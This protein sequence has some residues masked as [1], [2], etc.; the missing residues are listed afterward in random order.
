MSN[1][2]L[3]SSDNSV[4]Q[5]LI[6]LKRQ[7][8]LRTRKPRN[9][10]I[11]CINSVTGREL[12]YN[13]PAY[14]KALNNRKLMVI[15]TMTEKKIK[16]LKTGYAISP[17]SNKPIKISGTAFNKV[18]ASGE[19][20][21]RDNNSFMN[22]DHS[23]KEDIQNMKQINEL[24]VKRQIDQNNRFLNTVKIIYP[25]K[26]KNANNNS[27]SVK[28][29]YPSKP[30]S[31][32]TSE[33]PTSKYNMKY[34]VVALFY[35]MESRDEK[36]K[37]YKYIKDT[38]GK[39]H[40]QFLCREGTVSNKSI[41][42]YE[43]KR[44]YYSDK[45]F[46]S[47]CKILIS[48]ESFKKSVTSPLREY[49][50]CIIIKSVTDLPE[51]KEHRPLD[52]DLFNEK[53]EFAVFNK[54]IYY[55]INKS[56]KNFN[57]LFGV[58]VSIRSSHSNRCYVNLI[59][60]TWQKYFERDRLLEPKYRKYN[61]TLDAEYICDLCEINYTENDI[62]LSM[63]KSLKFFEKF[64]LG[65]LVL[66]PFG[67]I[68]KHKPIRNK[69]ISPSSLYIFINDRHCY[70][71][72]KNI[73]SIERTLWEKND[74]A[75]IDESFLETVNNLNNISNRYFIRTGLTNNKKAIFISSLDD[76]SE[77]VRNV[78]DESEQ[79]LY[80]I[81]SGDNL[82]NI[83]IDMVFG[84]P[85]YK[86]KVMYECGKIWSISFMVGNITGIITL[87]DVKASNDRDWLLTEQEYKAYH[88]ADDNFY[89]GLVQEKN[90][91]YYNPQVKLIEN[92]YPIGPMSGCFK[93]NIDTTKTYI[94][95]DSRKAYTSDFMD[96]K[97]YPVFGYFDI[98]LNYNNQKIEDYNQYIVKCLE[99]TPEAN[100]LFPRVY[101]RVTGYKL[102][103][104]GKT[105]PKY[106]VLKYRKP[107]TLNKSNSNELVEQVWET[108]ISD[109]EDNNKEN[110]K[111][112]VNKNLG[113]I[114]KKRNKRSV[115]WVFKNYDEAFYYQSKIGGDIHPI[116][117]NKW[118]VKDKDEYDPYENNTFERPNVVRS[119]T[120]VG[121]FV[122]YVL[123]INKE[124][125]L[126][127]GFTPIK[128]LVYDIRSL[129]N[130]NTYVK[131]KS[132]NITPLGIKTDSI[133]IRNSDLEK[134]KSLFNWND[135]IGCFKIEKDKYLKNDL[136]KKLI[137]N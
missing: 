4:G 78:T 16:P 128:D 43:F 104:L 107:N 15:N 123:V 134:V 48:D 65:L 5:M 99:D 53:N 34:S 101:N 56:A 18:A 13:S 95:I 108:R 114:E 84:T 36:R 30:K 100:I 52:E 94:G 23:M 80:F 42:E 131:L 88:T 57:E 74:G 61:I 109:N 121:K 28:I 124:A 9:G 116:E 12:S 122:A 77:N 91:S 126:I 120:Q 59:V 45:N 68:Y 118:L 58:D 117:E 35:H 133:L 19:W 21:Y 119:F 135:E 73:K 83:L 1:G 89:N 98:F 90:M 87:T 31:I 10:Q 8:G 136:I 103:R 2:Q 41:K 54:N 25:S 3:L 27:N 106:I 67:V 71:I 110:K 72:N 97:Q 92:Q 39:Y 81:Y 40:E 22:I 96:I 38:D 14:R 125:E 69:N 64:K 76:V 29:I 115:S 70:K 111:F 63:K 51:G 130:Y 112:I 137:I 11:K 50:Y 105:A 7:Q 93:P 6:K 113:L 66:G 24:D 86:P 26:V 102:N 127:N 47:L 46:E 37:G 32:D 132:N 55:N 85:S 79:V 82:D 20:I 49:I 62:G 60:S 129:K 44:T 33:A 75:M 17:V